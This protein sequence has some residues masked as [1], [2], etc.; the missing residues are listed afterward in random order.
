MNER[1]NWKFCF[2]TK[3]VSEAISSKL[4]YHKGRIAWWANRRS[5][6]MEK[7]KEAGVKVTESLVAQYSTTNLSNAGRGMSVNLDQELQSQ[8]D[9]CVRKVNEHEKAKTAFERWNSFADSWPNDK[10]LDLT[11]EDYVYF[12][13]M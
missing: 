2:S 12:F 4:G 9:E 3:E 6:V 10:M 13:C 11:Y 1:D 7:L 5:E 8:L